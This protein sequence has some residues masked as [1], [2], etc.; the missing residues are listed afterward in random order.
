MF[1]SP[2]IFRRSD[3]DFPTTPAIQRRLIDGRPGGRGGAARVRGRMAGSDAVFAA[4]DIDRDP[5]ADRTI[6]ACGSCKA[7]PDAHASSKPDAAGL[8]RRPTDP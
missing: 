6:P 5:E 7:R 1:D 8:S 3:P 4:A 2:R